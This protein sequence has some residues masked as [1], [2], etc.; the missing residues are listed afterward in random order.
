MNA[1]I[2]SLLFLGFAGASL[3]AHPCFELISDDSLITAGDTAE[4]R[5]VLSDSAAADSIDCGFEDVYWSVDPAIDVN[6]WSDS[7]IYWLSTTRANRT[8]TIVA[9]LQQAEQQLRDTF[10][11]QVEPDETAALGFEFAPPSG[12]RMWLDRSLDSLT[13][14]DAHTDVYGI[15]RDRFGNAVSAAESLEVS[16]GEG[17]VSAS[18]GDSARLTL[19]AATLNATATLYARSGTLRDTLRV[20][21]P[22]QWRPRIYFVGIGN[23]LVD[24]PPRPVAGNAI[25]ARI[26]LE[27]DSGL[28]P[29]V[30]RALARFDNLYAEEPLSS[31]LFPGVILANDSVVRDTIPFGDSG[32]VRFSDGVAEIRLVMYTKPESDSHQVIVAIDGKADTTAVIPLGIQP[33]KLLLRG[34]DGAAAPDTLSAGDTISLRAIGEDDYNN[35]RREYCTWKVSDAGEAV[36]GRDS[37]W[38]LAVRG[39]RR[40]DNDNVIVKAVSTRGLINTSRTLF[41]RGYGAQLRAAAALDRDGD[42]LFDGMRLSFDRAVTPRDTLGAGITA[43]YTHEGT[44][45]DFVSDSIAL[46]R[47]DSSVVIVTMRENR[48]DFPAGIHQTDWHPAL[49]INGFTDIANVDSFSCADSSG[50]AA[51]Y[52]LA[53][54]DTIDGEAAT[55]VTVA[56][57]EAIAP[58]DSA[59]GWSDALDVFSIWTGDSADDA[60]RR[61]SKIAQGGELDASGPRTV[62]FVLANA[63]DTAHTH[64]VKIDAPGAIADTLGNRSND[65]GRLYRLIDDRGAAPGTDTEDESAEPAKQQRSHGNCGDCG[66]GVELAILPLLWIKTRHWIRRARRRA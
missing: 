7:L 12:E 25:K 62:S 63:L 39:K 66:T 64:W 65:P 23:S 13:L 52:A 27:T 18:V 22:R 45:F 9:T 47:S 44:R 50:P 26:H 29:G 28:A 59:A 21:I 32:I 4:V 8:V 10:E 43:R 1:T 37:A 24:T 35:R 57:G 58:A 14:L 2:R 60:V 30:G 20:T 36:S 11:I 53:Q 17:V 49:K 19:S 34:D 31:S 41:F 5:L 56:F 54:G 3:A 16:G 46:G 15:I 51:W 33:V 48:A 6:A 55:R 61:E 42:G 40:K 38:T